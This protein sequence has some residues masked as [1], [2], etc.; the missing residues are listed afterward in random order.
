MAASGDRSLLRAR[1]VRRRFE[2]AAASFD[3]FAFVH[4]T[5]REALLARLE[6]ILIDARIVLDLGCATGAAYK[7]LSRRFRGARM[8]AMDT[9]HAML[10]QAAKQGN[11]FTRYK[12][13]QA[14]ATA[15]PLQDHSVDVVFCNLLLPWLPDAAVLFAEAARVLRRDGLLAFATLGPDSF[16]RLRAAWQ[17]VDDEPHVQQ[18]TDMHDLGDA[19]VRAG[20]RDP[21]LDV[22]RLIVSYA[23]SADLYRDLRGCAARN[24]LQ[25]RRS[26]LTGKQRFARMGAA[27]GAPHE[28]KGIEIELEL[29]YGHCWG[30]GQRATGGEFH[31]AATSIG[32]R[33]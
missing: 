31:I 6:P 16:S 9:S 10:Q 33:G 21:V 24:C 2:R 22:D 28:E 12:L 7:S 32:R 3:E 17:S 25:Q 15:I 29:V 20:L 8:L 23:H 13:L 27:L 5:T 14:D 26:S 30:R 11:W 4:Q 19:A 18:F 1:D